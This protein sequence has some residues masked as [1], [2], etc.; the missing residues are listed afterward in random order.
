ML[1][2]GQPDK[3]LTD[4]RNSKGSREFSATSTEILASGVDSE[5]LL[6]LVFVYRTYGH[7]ALTAMSLLHSSTSPHLVQATITCRLVIPLLNATFR[8]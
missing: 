4:L 7:L 8:Q 2:R 6:N 5:T 1:I 3:M